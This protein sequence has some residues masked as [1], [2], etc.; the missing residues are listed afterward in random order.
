MEH[1]PGDLTPAAAHAENAAMWGAPEPYVDPRPN[2]PMAE[3]RFFMAK[4]DRRISRL[5]DDLAEAEN[6]YATLRE[7]N[8]DLRRRL[9]ERDAALVRVVR[10]R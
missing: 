6:R 9:A 1:E 3:H 10:T 8:R 2:V 5:M 4:R 7:E